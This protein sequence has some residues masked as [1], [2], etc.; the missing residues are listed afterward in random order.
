MKKG[1]ITF[2]IIVIVLAIIVSLFEDTEGNISNSNETNSTV[3]TEDY[4]DEKDLYV[5]ETE[6]YQEQTKKQTIRTTVL[7]TIK[8][9]EYYYY[10]E[11]PTSYENYNYRNSNSIGSQD[12][13]MNTNTKKFHYPWCSS[14][15]TIKP[16]NHQDF[17]GERD[18]LIDAGYVPCKRCNP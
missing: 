14:V 11:N 9:T 12:Y 17:Y 2:F 16:K 5:E 3:M 6:K 4:Y 8:T 18:E 1:C 10:Y 13:V 15:D 7:T